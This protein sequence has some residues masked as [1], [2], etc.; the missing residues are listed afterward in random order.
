[1]VPVWRFFPY[2]VFPLGLHLEG[3][4]CGSVLLSAAPWLP[5]GVAPTSARAGLAR[6][7]AA[8][9]LPLVWTL[10]YKCSSIR[11]CHLLILLYLCPKLSAATWFPK[12]L[13]CDVKESS[14]DVSLLVDCADRRLTEV[15]R[16]IPTNVTNLTL[17][18]NHIP[19][20]SQKSF[21]RLQN[22]VEID[23][24]CNCVPVRLGP[25]DHVCTERL[26]IEDSSFTS[27]TLLKSLYL[28]GNQLLEIPRGLPQHL[29]LLSLEAN[30]IFSITK[31]NLT[32]VVN[33]EILYLGQNCYYR[34]P[35]NVSFYI[36]NDAF[37]N[38]TNLSVLSLKSNNIT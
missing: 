26:Y 4:D 36:E 7:K 13:P 17:T 37:Y 1:G 16:G 20:I 33:L 31:G 28:D 15:P 21:L 38:L 30:S 10:L 35:C 14:E 5:E 18:I 32:D 23:L 11:H 25:K 2:G 27:L 9:N 3:T 12:S 29:Q 22:L 8:R 19:H 34:N 24:R 6:T